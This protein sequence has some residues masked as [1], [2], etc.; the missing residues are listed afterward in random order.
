MASSGSGYDL[1]SSTFS[2]DG[3]IFQVEYAS[4]AVENA[5]TALGLR[6]SDGVVLCVEK[7]LLNKM[8]LPE[9]NSRRVHTVGAHSGVAVTGFVSDGRQ[10][11]NRAREEASNYLETYGSSVPPQVLADRISTYMHYFTLHGALRPFG[12]SALVA[13]YDADEKTHALYM[14]EPSGVS[15]RYFACAAGKGRQPARTELEK[16]SAQIKEDSITCREGAKQLARIIHVLH[17]SAKDKPFELEMSWI[18]EESKWSHKGVP[19]TVIA[20]SV[21]WAKQAIAD[22]EEEDEEDDDEMEE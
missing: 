17:D 9:T 22:A 1:S 20:E 21:A 8:L 11:V 18:C 4:K 10:I 3:R 19:R 14:V 15:H 6:C 2:P 13:A 5:G 7:P 12:A 16:L